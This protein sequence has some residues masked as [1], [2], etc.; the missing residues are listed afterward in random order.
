MANS[1][2]FYVEYR[3][4]KYDVFQDTDYFTVHCTTDPSSDTY[5]INKPDASDEEIL[6]YVQQIL[7]KNEWEKLV[8]IDRIEQTTRSVI[9]VP[10]EIVTC[11]HC[12][13]SDFVSKMHNFGKF[14]C[15]TDCYEQTAV[16]SATWQIRIPFN[17]G[18]IQ[19]RSTKSAE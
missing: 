3:K 1:V 5:V 2:R 9:E 12:G 10:E 17:S 7:N 11:Y 15:S 18:K 8:S 14:Y 16:G 4:R 19:W 6:A 13:K